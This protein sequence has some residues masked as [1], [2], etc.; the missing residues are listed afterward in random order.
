MDV[1][2]YIDVLRRHKS[3]IFGPAFAAVVVATV[4]AFLWPDTYLSTGVVRVVPPKVP[5]WYIKNNVNGD[6]SGR[7][8]AM[9]Q[10]VLNKQ[11]LQAIITEFDLY[12]KELKS[13]PMEDVFESMRNK[14]ITINPL[15]TSGQGSVPGKP[16]LPAF[17]IGFK[18]RD[19]RV[20]QKVAQ[21][22]MADLINENQKEVTQ[23]T[24]ITTEFLQT[25]RD[26]AKKVLDEIEGRLSDFRSRN[27]DK[28]PEDQQ[29]NMN[30]LMALQ[31]QIMN[32]NTSMSRVNQDKLVYESRLRVLK[33]QLSQLKDPST[34]EQPT[35]AAQV[36]KSE[37]LA[38]KDREITF[39]ENQLSAFRERYKDTHP[40]VQATAS[41]L[42]T[43]KR[44][45]EEIAKAE[46][47][48]KPADAAPVAKAPNPELQRQQRDLDA[49]VKQVEGVLSAKDL[50]MEDYRKQVSQLNAEI[51]NVR[52]RSASMPVGIKEYEALTRDRDMAKK[53]YEEREK[54]ASNSQIATD[55]YHN[56]QGETLEQIEI[57][58]LPETPTEPKRP[59]IILAGLGIGL[60]L[61]LFFAGAREVKDS[62]LKNLK[63][64]RAYTQLPILGSIPL[65][66]NDLIVRR[67]RRLAWLA[68][69]TACLVGVIVMTSSV[70]YYYATRV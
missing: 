16:A 27:L 9:L 58:S 63:D 33:D 4:V 53:E 43:A 45:R 44:Q 70:A 25:K 29:R 60:I 47:S 7:F 61:G 68:W 69:A 41:K 20:A 46:I 35:A 54:N 17:Q 14:D 6:I 37:K 13:M 12:K 48:T 65:L 67:R 56:N 66:E 3:W 30:Q 34:T 21:K 8:N 10:G 38:E 19:R 52:A 49:G 11:H 40:D 50:E 59:V 28:L 62:S 39:Y 24:N 31:T 22:I 36:Q 32:L 23:S 26:E 57:A 64:V 51:A 5:D 55:V 18:Y 15:N 42:A 2:D 1:E